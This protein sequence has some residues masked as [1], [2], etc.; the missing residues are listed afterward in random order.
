[1]TKKS[2]IEAVVGDLGEKKRWRALQR[3]IKALPGDY[4][5]AYKQIQKY[6]WTATG[7]ETIQPLEALVDLF[8]EGA[9]AHRPVLDIT[10]TDVA[11]VVDELV[12]GEQGYFEKRR[13]AL[14]EA[15]R[16]LGNVQ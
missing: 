11:A 9:A 13:A 10:G 15:M 14:N 16:K 12:Y 7:I 5:T 8:E 1:M 2:L 4:H 6:V 3:R